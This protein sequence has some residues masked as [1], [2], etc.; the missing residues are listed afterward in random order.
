MQRK[1]RGGGESS[2]KTDLPLPFNA[3]LRVYSKTDK[4]N[5]H[6]ESSFEAIE[7]LRFGRMSYKG[8]N[9]EI[10]RLQNG[11]S[12]VDEEEG[13]DNESSGEEGVD[14]T[15]EE[16]AKFYKQSRHEQDGASSCSPP[17]KR[18]KK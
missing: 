9:L 15:K 16:M 3:N 6:F 10:E 17:L 11:R 5:Y 12:S 2:E 1:S 14:V 4:S 18:A 13:E 7:N 8:M